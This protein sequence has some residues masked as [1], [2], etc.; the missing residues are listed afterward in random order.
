[1]ARL[2]LEHSS[3]VLK[4]YPFR[5]RSLTIG[6]NVDNTIVMD[7]PLVSGYHARIDKRGVDYILTDLQSTNGTFLNDINIVSHILSHGDR[8]MIGEHAIL[9]I[10][11]E[12]AKAYEEVENL[13]L[14]KTTIR[15]VSKK[16]E[17]LSQQ[18]T[19]ER[20]EISATEVMHPR[21]LGRLAPILL[22]I[23]ILTASGWYIL[24]YEPILLKSF[25]SAAIRTK[26][27]DTETSSANM[28]LSKSQS[29]EAE[30]MSLMTKVPQKPIPRPS[31]ESSE[32]LLSEKNHSIPIST[33]YQEPSSQ[34]S[35]EKSE[36]FEQ[37]ISNE[38]Y[39]PK[40]ILEG[41][42]WASES[43]DSFAVINGQ[44]FKA[45]GSVKGIKIVEIGKRHVIIQD[46]KDDTKIKL[47][48]R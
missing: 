40:Y 2:I 31:K 36:E 13:D 18:K 42:A 14:N 29:A 25:F 35:L 30:S 47:T 20:S 3:A 11:T 44:M 46:S 6:R 33:E 12:M 19:I 24:N 39:K 17:P 15:G 38:T 34:Q 4:D 9:F 8:I 27:S 7:D 23:F 37:R 5:K 41:I 16:K 32:P 43:K 48:L 21:L 28:T 45:G 26:G 1:M 22:S 10:G